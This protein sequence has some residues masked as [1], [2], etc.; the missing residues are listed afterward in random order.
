MRIVAVSDKI[1]VDVVVEE[2]ITSGGIFIPDTVKDKIQTMGKV[3][4]VGKDVS[5]IFVGDT[6]MFDQYTG[7]SF[8]LSD[9]VNR[10]SL[11]LEEISAVIR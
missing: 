2:N 6:V 3:I 7:M 8:K 11:K 5:D 9:G 10:K 1:I 4:S